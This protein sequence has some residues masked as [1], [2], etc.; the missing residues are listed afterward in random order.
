[1]LGRP[2]RRSRWCGTSPQRAP[3]P[4]SSE[5]RRAKRGPWNAYKRTGTTRSPARRRTDVA[6]A[7]LA[8]HSP[9]K[10]TEAR[11][12]DPRRDGATQV[13]AAGERR[14]RRSVSVDAAPARAGVFRLRTHLQ[15]TAE[16]TGEVLHVTAPDHARELFPVEAQRPL[17]F[18]ARAPEQRRADA[19]R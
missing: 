10:T 3:E 7:R 19:A 6:I 8:R 5:N 12:E 15:V 2:C 9:P 11:R 4:R 14:E 13:K 16:V 1:M 17:F 18:V